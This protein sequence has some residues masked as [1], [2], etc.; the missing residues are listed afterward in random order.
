VGQYTNTTASTRVMALDVVSKREWR[1]R[2]GIPSHPTCSEA[3]V[4]EG[5]ADFPE[6]ENFFSRRDG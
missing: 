5:S 3:L 4:R 2:P 6:Y 1:L